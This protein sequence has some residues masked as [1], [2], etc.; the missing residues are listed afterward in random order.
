MLLPLSLKDV[1]TLSSLVPRRVSE[2]ATPLVSRGDT[3]SRNL[4][5]ERAHSLCRGLKA[6]TPRGPATVQN[7]RAGGVVGLTV[8]ENP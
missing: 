4:R 5:A 1:F 6:R 8:E 7:L 3:S 2:V